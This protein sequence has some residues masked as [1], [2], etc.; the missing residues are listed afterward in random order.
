[1]RIVAESRS[2]NSVNIVNSI[3]E[4]LESSAPVGSSASTM[5]GFVTIALAAAKH[6]RC[7]NQPEERKQHECSHQH[8]NQGKDSIFFIVLFYN[9]LVSILRNRDFCTILEQ[10]LILRQKMKIA[11]PGRQ[12]LRIERKTKILYIKEV[13]SKKTCSWQAEGEWDEDRKMGAGFSRPIGCSGF[14]GRKGRTQP[15]CES[16]RQ[17]IKMRRSIW[18][19]FTLTLRL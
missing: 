11:F 19:Y 6:S 4:E 18:I 3:R 17:A 7:F 10:K 2:F 1:M 12:K 5:A 13:K 14:A 9:G 16:K 8:T 15:N